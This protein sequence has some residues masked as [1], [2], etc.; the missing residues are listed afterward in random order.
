L[1]GWMVSAMP[2]LLGL[3]LNYMRPDL[4]Q[5]MLQHLF[6]YVLV[7]IVLVMEGLGFLLIRRIV[8]IDV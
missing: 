4:I 2:L 5:P 3:V 7:G 1:Q 8:N 6:G